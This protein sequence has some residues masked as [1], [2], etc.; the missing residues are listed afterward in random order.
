LKMKTERET[1]KVKLTFIGKAGTTLIPCEITGTE[2]EI[3][4]IEEAVIIE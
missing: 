1:K 2:E 3:K 4:Q